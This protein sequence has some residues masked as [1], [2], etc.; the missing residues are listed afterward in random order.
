MA[1][2]GGPSSKIMTQRKRQRN[3][4]LNDGQPLWEWEKNEL[5]VKRFSYVFTARTQHVF[6]IFIFI[7]C[8][9]CALYTFLLLQILYV[10][11]SFVFD[12]S[13]FLSECNAR[14]RDSNVTNKPNR[15]DKKKNYEKLLWNEAKRKRST[16][17]KKHK[18]S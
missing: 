8:C 13:S 11:F 9:S 3:K 7:F 2:L 1:W 14:D 15:N 10:C 4:Y 17:N 18:Q 5:G 6:Y 12:F 16:T